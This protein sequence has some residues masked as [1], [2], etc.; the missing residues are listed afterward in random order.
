M[1]RVGIAAITPLSALGLTPPRQID[2]FMAN[3]RCHLCGVLGAPYIYRGLDIADREHLGIPRRYCRVHRPDYDY[4]P[5][6]P[7]EEL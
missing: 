4:G 5:E 2:P 1:S 7:R 3:D 6:W